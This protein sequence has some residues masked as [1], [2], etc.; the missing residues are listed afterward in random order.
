MT[1]DGQE[2]PTVWRTL[3]PESFLPAIGLVIVRHAVMDRALFDA[4]CYV[5][6]VD[7]NVGVSFL[8]KAQ[9]TTARA[10]ILRDLATTKVLDDPQA[11][12]IHVLA[13]LIVKCCKQ[14]NI[15]AHSVPYFWSPAAGEVGYFRDEVQTY[16]QIK[17]QP[18][19]RASLKS[20]TELADLM[21]LITRWLELMLPNFIPEGMPIETTPPIPS[22]MWTDP[23]Q[24]AW[25]DRYQRKAASW[26]RSRD[27]IPKDTP[28][29]PQSSQA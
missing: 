3:L 12:K 8:L 2:P 6:K 29:P 26:N 11:I 28:D 13:D 1:D 5:A 19:Y 18:P 16:P 25:P 17:Q 21:D 27:Y 22:R 14:R 24:F 23:S 10:N 15:L 4:I 20:L 7:R 9:N